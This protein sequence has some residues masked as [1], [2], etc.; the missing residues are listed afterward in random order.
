MGPATLL[1][2]HR[3]HCRTSRLDKFDSE[4]TNALDRPPASLANDMS[5]SSL[6]GHCGRGLAIAQQAL[7]RPLSITRSV[8]HREENSIERA[9][10]AAIPKYERT[11]RKAP[12]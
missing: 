5:S 11:F 12:L 3:L 4:H 2:V 10:L 6:M 9:L 8:W 7:A 1:P